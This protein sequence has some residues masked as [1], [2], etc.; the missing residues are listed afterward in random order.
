MNQ[1]KLLPYLV[2]LFFYNISFADTSLDKIKG[3]EGEMGKKTNTNFISNIKNVLNNYKCEQKKF[4]PPDLI[5]A[6][7]FPKKET[8]RSNAMCFLIKYQSLK[9]ISKSNV[10]F[11]QG[12]LVAHEQFKSNQNKTPL[13]AFMLKSPILRK[14]NPNSPSQIAY[15]QNSLHTSK[16][17]RVP[18]ALGPIFY[19]KEDANVI[20]TSIGSPILYGEGAKDILNKM[21]KQ[22][23]LLINSTLGM[24]IPNRCGRKTAK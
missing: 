22:Q 13:G 14:S 19:P 7:D 4:P 18:Q 1:Y 2:V 20:R 5:L 12:G 17:N 11:G 21:S 8:E 15:I 24:N 10:V 23:T 3:L 16:P 6:C 9:I